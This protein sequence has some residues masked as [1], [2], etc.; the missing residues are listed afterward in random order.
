MLE[1]LKNDFKY[2][3]NI[4]VYQGETIPD[5][6]NKKPLFINGQLLYLTDKN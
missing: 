5:P 4:Y 2:K 1:F 3:Q 6:K